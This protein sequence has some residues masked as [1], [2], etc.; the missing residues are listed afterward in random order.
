MSLNFQED[1]NEEAQK[2]IKALF[3]DAV[4]CDQRTFLYN[5][6]AS[7]ER[8]Q[9]TEIANAAG[10]PAVVEVNKIGET[11]TLSDGTEYEVTEKGWKKKDPK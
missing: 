3:G 8:R 11:K 9:M 10:Q 1:V 5:R 7:L 4:A 6:I 2:K